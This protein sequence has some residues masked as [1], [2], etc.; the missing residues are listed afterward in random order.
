MEVFCLLKRRINLR[1]PL[2]RNPLLRS[3]LGAWLSLA[4][5][6][7]PRCD[8]DKKLA[9]GFGTCREGSSGGGASSLLRFCE[10]G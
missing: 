2:V 9:V 6:I 4:Q 3:S 7:V 5:L 8:P 1:L 10:N